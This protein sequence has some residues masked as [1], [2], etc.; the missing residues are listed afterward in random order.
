MGA[1][2]PATVKLSGLVFAGEPVGLKILLFVRVV[3]NVPVPGNVTEFPIVLQASVPQ[4]AEPV[5][6]GPAR[7][8]PPALKAQ[9]YVPLLFRLVVESNVLDMVKV[10]TCVSL[11][12]AVV[13]PHVDNA[14][15]K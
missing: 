11:V 12:L 5:P 3:L 2:G 9:T 15:M 14:G 1:V 8:S 6:A 13:E 7:N 10:N 4:A